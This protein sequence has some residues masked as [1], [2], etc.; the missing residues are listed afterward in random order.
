[1]IQLPKRAQDIAGLRS[2]KMVAVRYH[3]TDAKGKAIW[4]CRCD[5]GTEKTIKAEQLTRGKSKSCGCST[6]DYRRASLRR[7]GQSRTPYQRPTGAFSSWAAMIQRCGNRKNAQ[8]A[9]YGGRGISVCERWQSFENFFADMGP[10]PDGCTLDRIDPDGGY[11][12][13]NC[14]WATRSEQSRNQR[15]KVRNSDIA[16]LLAAARRVVSASPL[17][18]DEAV[19][20]LSRA[21][22]AFENRRT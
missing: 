3:S 4:L 10:R 15:L 14:R 16:E 6:N 17:A 18:I 11:D 8:Y 12:P 20:D 5:C 13:A 21:I 1:M 19:Q 22:F 9:D 2:G 7:H